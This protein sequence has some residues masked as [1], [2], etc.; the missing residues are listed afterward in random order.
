[1]STVNRLAARLAGHF[2]SDALLRGALERQAYATDNSKREGR[3]DLIALPETHEQV[4]AAVTACAELGVPLVARGR[5]SNT[6][7]AS[8]AVEGGLVLSLERMQGI[9]AIRPGDRAA[10]VE[11]GVVNGE[12][13]RALATHGMFWAADPTSAPYAS[14]GGNIACNAGGPRT[15]KYGSARDNLLALRAVDGRGRAF[16]CGAAVTKNSTGFDLVRLLAGSEGTLAIITEAT[17]KLTPL[18]EARRG[19]RALYR[20][21]DAAAAAVARLMA[22]PVLPTT[23]EFMDDAAL[24]LLRERGLTLPAEAQALLLLDVDGREAT[25][26][27]AVEA[28]RAA[29]ST[30]GLL[31]FAAARS[32][33]ELESLWAA[34]RA[35]SPALRSVAPDKINEDVVVPVS[36]LPDLLARVRALSAEHAIPIVCFGH[37]GNGNLHVNLLFDGAV[38]GAR[39]RADACLNAVFSAV[40]DLGGTLSG[41]H[42]IGLAKRDFM[43]RAL[44]P[45]TL[46]LMRALKAQFDPRGILNPGKLLP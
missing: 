46:D 14:I 37:A 24:R 10:V 1:V 2:P 25:L 40:L 3:P 5:G 27:D 19:L 13:Q 36:R 30:E 42:G 26:D 17:L 41:E 15:L 16:R 12:L 21:V 18:A 23:L 11:P 22:Q 29:A 32:E 38:P 28:L 39:A 7:G 8:I 4:V 45:V 33:A 34:R 44:D 35:L 31:D 43:P 20:S 9:L 6:T